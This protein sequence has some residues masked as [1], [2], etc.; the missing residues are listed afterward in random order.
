M[1][2]KLPVPYA[3]WPVDLKLKHV[4][5][6]P[7]DTLV[8]FQGQYLTICELDYNILQV[9]I[10][11]TEKTTGTV[12]LGGFCLVED[13]FF[14]QWYRGR[15]QKKHSDLYDV[16]LIDHGNVLTV[17]SSHLAS[18]CDKL[19]MLPPKI[20]C[21]F[22]ANML[23]VGEKWD[24]LTVKFFSSLIGSEIT[25]YI[26]AVLPHKVLVLEAPDIN[27]DLTRLGFGKGV[28]KD[29]F[30]LLVE[31]LTEVPLKQNSEPVPDLLIEKQVGQEFTS[32]PSS[33]QCFQ[34]IL[35][36][37]G[38]KL[39][40]GRI[41]RAK[42]TA[43]VN[44][45]TFY[46]QLM[47]MEQDLKE[48]TETLSKLC[49][50]QCKELR[51][52][53]AGNMGVLCS[54]KGKDEK[55]HRGFVQQ[56]V[57]DG[58]ARVLFVDYGFC[59]SVKV[60]NILPLTSDFLGPSIMAFPCA[61]SCQSDQ[62]KMAQK[63]Q[64]GEFKRGLLGATLD[65]HIDHFSTQENLYF[66]T[67]FSTTEKADL[68]FQEM[69]RKCEKSTQEENGVWEVENDTENGN[70][71]QCN[72]S[73]ENPK[74][75]THIKEMK[76]SS[77]VG[78]VEHVVNPSDFWMRTEE[79][80]NAFEDMMDKLTNY[81]NSM[82]LNEGTMNY[83][84]PD[85]LCC[86]M[87][88]KD[89]HYYRAVITDVF[90]NGA[91]VFFMDFGNTEKVPYMCIKALP[92]RFTEEPAFALH[93]SLANVSSMEDVWTAN[94]TDFFKNIVL[95]KAL[96]AQILHKNNDKYIVELYE[97]REPNNI[98]IVSLMVTAKMAQYWSY[99]PR[100]NDQILAREYRAQQSK[101]RVPTSGPVVKKLHTP[102]N[103]RNAKHQKEIRETQNR[104]HTEEPAGC[105]R[106]DTPSKELK[107]TTAS[108][109]KPVILKVGSIL[110]V[111]CPSVFS[112]FEF[113]CQLQ[114]KS[115]DLN[116]LLKKLQDYYETHKDPFQPNDGACVV[117]FSKDGKWYRGS[118]CRK[119]GSVVSVFLVDFGFTVT[120]RVQNV[121]AIQ[122]EFLDL[123]A[124]AFKCSLYNLIEPTGEWTNETNRLLTDFMRDDF[125]ELKCIV[126]AVLYVEGKGLY[127]VVDLQ[128]PFVSAS[129]L[130]I[131]RGHARKC[132]NTKPLIS[133]YRPYSYVHS[134]FNMKIGGEELVYVTHVCSPWEFYFQLDRNTEVLESL[135]EKITRTKSEMQGHVWDV[136]QAKLCLAKYVD[137]MW[138]RGLSFAVQSHLHLNI[139]F[140]DFGNMHVVDKSNVLPI[141]AEATDLQFLPM[142]AVRCSLADIPKGEILAEVITW[143]KQH[144]VNKPLKAVITSRD[145][146]GAV[147][148]DLYDGDLQINQ[149]VKELIASHGPKAKLALD[150]KP[151][152]QE[153]ESSLGIKEP[154]MK[155]EAKMISRVKPAGR[156]PNKTDFKSEK[157]LN[158][159][160]ELVDDSKI[161]KPK[162]IPSGLREHKK[163]LPKLSDL[164]Q[165][166]IRPG[167]SVTGFVSHINT[168]FNFYIQFEED[169]Q[170]ILKMAE[171][172]NEVKLKENRNNLIHEGVH[173]D[174]LVAVK[175]EEDGSF[176]RAVVKKCTSSDLLV[177]F[178]DYGNVATVEKTSM[179][180]LSKT[181]VSQPR[182][183]VPCFLEEPHTFCDDDHFR[184]E[185]TDKR[186]SVQF[187]KQ[188]GSQWAVLMEVIDEAQAGVSS[189][190]IHSC[191]VD[192]TEGEVSTD[193]Q[194]LECQS[195]D[196]KDVT[197]HNTNT[198]THES[199]PGY[200]NLQDCKSN[201]TE[202]VPQNVKVQVQDLKPGQM[203]K[204]TVLSI[205]CNGDLYIS[206]LKNSE[207]L[208]VLGLT[209]VE[210]AYNAS[211]LPVMDLKEG[212][213]CL[214]QSKKHNKWYRA[215]VQNVCIDKDE[216]CV[217]FFDHVMVERSFPQLD[218]AFKDDYSVNDLSLVQRIFLLPIA[219]DRPYCSF[220][221]AVTD[222][223]EFYIMLEDLFLVM[224]DVSTILE[225]LP[226]DLAALPKA[227]LTPGSC[228]LVMSETK[229][230]WCRGE[231]IDVDSESV[232]IILVD[233]GHYEY[234]PLT[235]MSHLKS[236]PEQLTILPKLTYPCVLRGVKPA[237]GEQ[238]TDEAAIFF[239]ECISQ[240]NLLIY[241]RQY[242]FDSFWEVDILA[243]DVNIAKDLVD[244]GHAVYVDCMLGLG[245]QQEKSL[246]SFLDTSLSAAGIVPEN[247]M[248]KTNMSQGT[249]SSR[250]PKLVDHS[251]TDVSEQ[252]SLHLQEGS[253][254]ISQGN[255]RNETTSNAEHL[256]SPAARRKELTEVMPLTQRCKYFFHESLCSF[257]INCIKLL[258]Q[259]C[260]YVLFSLP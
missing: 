194:R 83:P 237:K 117:K 174:D 19:F 164:P 61:L 88:E 26:Q 33:F 129:Q 257:K 149:K 24:V 219:M 32:K 260:Q 82:E 240:R 155:S 22:F 201:Q 128:T 247:A 107:S 152:A 70:V 183:S 101:R 250:F 89:M 153:G 65:I 15:V 4:D 95:H 191:S 102:P 162:E 54:V 245:L 37:C 49:D 139:F 150:E 58:Q 234:V 253:V 223:G 175:Y 154:N 48:M 210:N 93:C 99:V 205:S 137:G 104:V 20:T 241:F 255:V 203:E 13:T 38:P 177:E 224:N 116:D 133:S 208:N 214:A 59:D 182:L 91:E 30:L 132:G 23:P 5:C 63:L 235:H 35:S 161:A 171:E 42:I 180:R 211:S 21:G 68:G 87:Y 186:L 232:L 165:S 51:E 217:F 109:F 185:V 227:L 12:E 50:S 225:S 6:N 8:H 179:R 233:Y 145:D 66:V 243:N 238:W 98:S 256:Q 76:K 7:G 96:L 189:N 169:E 84:E 252:P 79:R 118:I 85:S 195:Q 114:N 207:Q 74:D 2:A 72:R 45:S 170:P 156:S 158:K 173:T 67:L 105:A 167:F 206:L 204:G 18:A 197:N 187:V 228:C 125:P 40:V 122:P 41:E 121:Q 220:V 230:K 124:Q 1:D 138:Y 202:W 62:D 215:D 229:K 244:S 190:V 80:N 216:V 239:Q 73:K 172:L 254:C 36:Y 131:E 28:D 140:V 69:V 200:K 120:E 86:A 44:P 14:G 221:A 168:A 127:N 143:L 56:V 258:A 231:I 77:Y 188:V 166:K 31:M 94:S 246:V 226:E 53:H 134:L 78:F 119:V 157:S 196:E 46:C 92:L 151:V 248:K 199:K 159:D 71:L 64:L 218:T 112:P 178:I 27:T 198:E 141:P 242:V 209:I 60:E 11:N 123:E 57:P 176:Y 113:W 192:G 193:A 136:G 142:Q 75:A 34:N 106:T 160:T 29:T 126:Y 212:L 249:N 81:C 110:K 10:Q 251:M 43:A 144:I 111:R 3:L 184:E 181:G 147:I 148:C 108:T 115:C 236:L 135:M 47:S 213:E 16:F 55:W 25:G 222:P 39:S 52:K 163:L 100:Y 90:E 17:D 103:L 259:L 146:E 9:E 130:L 97:K